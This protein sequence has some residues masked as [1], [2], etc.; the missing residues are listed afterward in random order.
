VPSD[1]AGLL[2]ACG[3]PGGVRRVAIE[4]LEFDELPVEADG[5][6]VVLLA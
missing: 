1:Q 4:V 2:G 6:A 5:N 3:H